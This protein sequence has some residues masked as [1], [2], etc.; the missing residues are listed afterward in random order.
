[1]KE[2]K[3]AEVKNVEDKNV[4]KEEVEITLVIA[5][6]YHEIGNDGKLED[7]CEDRPEKA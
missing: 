3:K 7:E 4:N 1:M 5:C 2:A 6:P